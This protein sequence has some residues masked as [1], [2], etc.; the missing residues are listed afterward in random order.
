LIAVATSRGRRI[1]A[2]RHQ[3]EARQIELTDDKTVAA[4]VEALGC[5]AGDQ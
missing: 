4:I 1:V 5:S 3:R 2:S